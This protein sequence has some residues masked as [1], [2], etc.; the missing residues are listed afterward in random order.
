MIFLLNH[1]TELIDSEL[2]QKIWLGRCGG[3]RAEWREQ[4]K[5]SFVCGGKMK[6]TKN[7]LLFFC[8][9]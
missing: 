4:G 2:I 5:K 7:I 9:P 1:N 3:I 6:I 8:L